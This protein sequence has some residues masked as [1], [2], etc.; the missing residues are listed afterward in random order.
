MPHVDF[1][2]SHCQ[3]AVA[4]RDITPPVGM[5]HRMWGAA[6]HDRSTGI[7]R[8]L[9]ATALVLK[10]L[11]AAATSPE[12]ND[13]QD[14]ETQV[15]V[16]IDHCL[17]WTEE[18]QALVAGVCRIAHLEPHQLHIT[19]SH[20][21]AAGLMDPQRANLP[22]GELI[23]PYLAVLAERIG[24]AVCE[25]LQSI[26]PVR[27][28]YGEGRCGLARN[29]DF[30]DRDNELFVCGLNPNGLSDDTV[31]VARVTD[32][33][34]RT[35]A[36]LVNY[37]CHPTTLAW[38]NTLISPDFVGAMRE[39]TESAT[40]AP[41]LFLQGASGDL[42][43]RDGFVGDVAV[44]DRNGRELGHAALAALESVPRPSVRFEY[45]GPVVSGATIGAWDYARLP[46]QELEGKSD[47]QCRQ[48]TID[49]SYRADLPT[50][51]ETQSALAQWQADE[52][53]ALA[54]GDDARAR[55]CRAQVERMTRQLARLR[56]L[57]TGKTVPLVVA[58]WKLG[59][60]L[61]LLLPAEHYNV[62]QRSLRQRFQGRPMVIAT[63]TGGW[64]P[65]YLPAAETY[66]SEI[67][68]Q[69]IA[70]VERGSLE[71]VIETIG[72]HIA[73]LLT[74]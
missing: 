15:I 64:L 11:P 70:V 25:G 59:D 68:Q 47:W 6:T 58:L 46:K 52:A 18:M 57:P 29:R 72:D 10:A 8:P 32:E 66:D 44:A 22:G 42:G 13:T 21:H 67:Y 30:W 71:L 27:I 54:K 51:D 16:G 60:S 50:W 53:A 1:P 36:T 38:D 62:L 5:Y 7:H 69:S 28:V 39:L 35:I 17:L 48:F 12:R 31:V 55:D 23:A 65:G 74:T 37:A 14:S 73:R 19:F 3:G 20:T 33:N 9:L 40:Q 24:E 4:R 61:W 45:L 41:C 43:P 49:L 2:Q 56:G 26:R 63:M 34:D